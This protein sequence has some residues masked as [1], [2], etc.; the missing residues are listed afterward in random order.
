MEAGGSKSTEEFFM[1][2][3]LG[4]TDTFKAFTAAV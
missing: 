2:F 1:F 4:F 3:L